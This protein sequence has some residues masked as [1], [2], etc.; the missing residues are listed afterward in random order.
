MK[1]HFVESMDEVLR[2]ALEREMVALPVT[3]AVAVETGA[4]ERGPTERS[5]RSADAGF[6]RGAPPADRRI[7]A[8][9]PACARAPGSPLRAEFVASSAK[10][11]QFPLTAC[12]KS[13]F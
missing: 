11:D 10:P 4:E 13:R 9:E 8:R 12:P 6:G 2:I 3:P 1:L 5:R 7:A